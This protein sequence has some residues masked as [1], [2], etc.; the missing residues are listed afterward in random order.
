MKFEICSRDRDSSARLGKIILPRCGISTPLFMPVATQGTIKSLPPLFLEKAGVQMLVA[1][2]Y[3]LHLR[4]GE[5]IIEKVGGLHKFMGWDNGI[6]TDSGGFQVVSLADLNRVSDEGVRFQSHI[7]GS[8]ELFTPEKV[9]N[10]QLA[11]GTD[12]VMSFDEPVLYPSS[13]ASSEKAVQRTTKWAKEGKK[14]FDHSGIANK[15]GI[16]GIVQG[17]T[18]KDLRARST[19]DLIKMGFDGYAIGGLAIGEPKSLQLDITDFTSHL[20]PDD[21]PRYLMGVGYPEDIIDAVSKGI[22]MFDCVIPTRNARTGTVFTREGKLVIK[23]APFSADYLPIE[24]DCE[25]YTCRNFSRAYL[26]H[27]FNAGEILGPVLA[28]LHNIHFF[29]SLMREIRD[30]LKK[31]EFTS[32]SKRFLSEYMNS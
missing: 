12:I 19:E 7:D 29:M 4:P 13:F 5:N 21:K 18:Y 16:F 11:L 14:V 22:D 23:N 30:S 8:Y 15:R 27:L 32:W 6:L 3:H 26:R 28:T 1:N 24:E 10:I 20:L 31:G 25:C 2:T 17:G 9:I